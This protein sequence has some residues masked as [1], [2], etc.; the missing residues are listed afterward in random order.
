MDLRSNPSQIDASW[1]TQVLQKNYPGSQVNSL[2][3][4]SIGTGQVGEN[5]RFALSGEGVPNSI[6]GKFP[7]LDP[8]RKQTGIMQRNYVREV[9]FYQTLQSQ[10]S[11]QT[12]EIFH[13]DI[14]LESHEFVLLMED[15]SPG[16]QGDQLA[17]C[18][19]D[20]A[21]LALEQLA[22]LQGPKWGDSELAQIELLGGGSAREDTQMLTGL[23]QNLMPGYLSRYAARLSEAEVRATEQLLEILPDYQKVY[24]N[25]P[26]VLIHV[27]YRLDNMMFG[28]PYPLTV[29]DWQ[30][31]TMGCPLNDASYF[32]GTSLTPE[33]RDSE[34]RA[35]LRL[36]LEVLSSYGITLSFDQAFL[37]YR[38][39]APA[40]MIMALIASMIVGETE[41]GNDMFMA[42]AKR[43]IAMAQS[44]EVLN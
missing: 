38:N 17:G 1:L 19:A 13:A 37:Y 30:S 36:Y 8:V 2:Q 10:V 26:P 34:E 43:S 22:H 18:S 31:L 42:M 16:V 41:R 21:A 29:V 4:E 15:L 6:V 28:G 32:M 27:D 3:A 9:F 39:Y 20:Q 12:P 44:L 40:G 7:S 24:Q 5:V 23:Y 35:L 33:V 25:Q 14:D 11:I